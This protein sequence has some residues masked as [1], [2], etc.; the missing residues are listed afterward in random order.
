MRFTLIEGGDI[1]TPKHA[2]VQPLL[3][4]DSKIAKLGPVE[5]R[6]RLH[7][8]LDCFDMPPSSI[9]PTHVNRTEALV[10]DAIALAQGGPAHRVTISS[11]AHT[12]SGSPQ[13]LYEQFVAC[14]R[15]AKLPLGTVLACVTSSAA[16]ALKLSAK[17]NLVPD[18]D[19]DVLVLKHDSLEI[20]H[21]FARGRHV[22]RDG[23]YVEPS[24][25]EQQVESGKE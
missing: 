20:M 7:E 3:L 13:K 4:A 21:L 10:D 16:G 14:M 1:Y 18:R 5:Q 17:G 22:I 9:Y 15:E 8:L 19:A 2:G 12:P 11:D 23:Q 6:A 24:R 25:Q